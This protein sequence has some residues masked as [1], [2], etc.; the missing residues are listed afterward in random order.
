MILGESRGSIGICCVASNKFLT[1]RVYVDWRSRGKL[2]LDPRSTHY[3][4]FNRTSMECNRSTLDMYL[5]TT[6]SSVWKKVQSFFEIFSSLSLGPLYS[7]N[8]LKS[9]DLPKNYIFFW[10]LAHCGYHWEFG[11]TDGIDR[12]ERGVGWLKWWTNLHAC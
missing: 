7:K 1:L 12:A 2:M 8:F 10:I 4:V 6:M 5:D 9:S 11:L 3:R